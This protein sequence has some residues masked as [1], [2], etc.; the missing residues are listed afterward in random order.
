MKKKLIC[1]LLTACFG[2]LIYIHRRVI[3]ALI[4]G[5]EMP[6]A[7]SWHFWCKK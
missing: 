5:D 1:F 4:T 2:A 6:E 7:P 3:L